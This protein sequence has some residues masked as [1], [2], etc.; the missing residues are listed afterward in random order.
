M[1]HARF[2]LFH[3]ACILNLVSPLT[4]TVLLVKQRKGYILGCLTALYISVI[5][6]MAM[7]CQTIQTFI[8]V[9]E[10]P[11][12][13]PLNKEVST[14]L[15]SYGLIQNAV[16]ALA[17]IIADSLLVSITQIPLPAWSAIYLAIAV[18]EVLHHLEEKQMDSCWEHNNNFHRDKY[19][20]LDVFLDRKW[21]PFL[22]LVFLP[23]WL[24][25]G[26]TITFGSTFSFI[27][28]YWVISLVITII[29]TTLIVYRIINMARKTNTTT[30]Y[31]PIVEILVESGAMYTIAIIICC[32]LWAQSK[33][34]RF[35]MF[36][37]GVYEASNV[38]YSLLIPVTVSCA[39]FVFCSRQTFNDICI[40]CRELRPHW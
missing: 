11:F 13:I 24:K 4:P 31:F 38:F 23:I 25:N 14:H 26:P 35:S 1:S 29:S 3:C 18:L 2:P 36:R 22:Y 5:L 19:G 17:A 8:H 30:P 39:M 20:I 10:I 34:S 28:F 33:P 7:E 16:S 21:T 15:I 37:F 6:N 27:I 12:A 40:Y 32:A 9:L